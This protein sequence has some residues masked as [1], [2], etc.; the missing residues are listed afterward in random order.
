MQTVY[1]SGSVDDEPPRPFPRR[2]EPF[3]YRAQI[4]GRPYI[5]TLSVM[6]RR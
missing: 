2:V 5:G 1:V 6:N 3:D 4:V